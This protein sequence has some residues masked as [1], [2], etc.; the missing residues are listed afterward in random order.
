MNQDTALDD[1]L[2]VFKHAFH[3][4]TLVGVKYLGKY[5]STEDRKFYKFIGKFEFSPPRQVFDSDIECNKK[6][7]LSSLKELDSEESNCFSRKFTKKILDDGKLRK[8]V[9]FQY[10]FDIVPK[11]IVDYSLNPQTGKMY[12]YVI[13]YG[14][15]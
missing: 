1:L 15:M 5:R 10:D 14:T 9:E 6:Q 13:G 4:C 2:E 3:K 7:L 11:N 8:K 12:L